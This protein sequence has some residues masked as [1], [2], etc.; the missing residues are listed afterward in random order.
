MILLES[1]HVCSEKDKENALVLLNE[2]AVPLLIYDFG[3]QIGKPEN[4]KFIISL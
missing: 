1:S 3:T 4:N 2:Y